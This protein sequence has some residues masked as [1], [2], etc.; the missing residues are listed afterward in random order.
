MGV[1]RGALALPWILKFSAK[2]GCF[3]T[4]EWEKKQISLLLAP[5]GKI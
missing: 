1:G 4:F 5:T 2:K 3:L